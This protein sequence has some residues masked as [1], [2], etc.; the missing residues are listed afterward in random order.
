MDT[1]TRGVTVFD[2]R[3]GASARTEKR[4]ILQ[5]QEPA[6]SHASSHST[7]SKLTDFFQSATVVSSVHAHHRRVALARFPPIFRGVRGLRD[8]ENQV[9]D[10]I[11]GTTCNRADGAVNPFVLNG[12]TGGQV[13]LIAFSKPACNQ[14]P[15]RPNRISLSEKTHSSTALESFGGRNPYILF[16][17]AEPV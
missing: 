4:P 12:I 16:L 8:G 2:S 10:H 14:Q 7:G 17:P 9:D 6:P 11:A 13:A 5:Y 15:K 1:D 3:D